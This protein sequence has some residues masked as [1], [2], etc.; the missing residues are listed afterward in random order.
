[1]KKLF[2]CLS[3]A[4]CCV[5]WGQRNLNYDESKVPQFA[6]P[7][8][9]TCYDGSKVTTIDDW[10]R[11]RRPELLETFATQE[12][13]RT[14]PDSIA[15]SYEVVSENSHALGDKAT[16]R[17][18]RF[19]FSGNGRRHEAIAMTLVPNH[20][21]GKVPVFVSYSFI[22]N[23]STTTDTTIVYSAGVRMVQ[24]PGD[25]NWQRGNQK[26]RWPFEQIIDRGYAVITMAYH[27]IY[28]D[29]D[30]PRWLDN[31]VLS[32]FPDYQQY[33]TRSDAWEAVGAWAWGSS[34]M[35]DYLYTQDWADMQRIALMGHSRQG[36]A[37][38]WA[39]AQDTRFRV[40][41]SNCSGASGAALAKRRYGETVGLLTSVRPWWFCAAYAFYT[42]REEAMPFDQHELIA[43]IAPRHVYVASAEDDAPA[44]PKGEFLATSYAEPVYRLYGLKGLDT[45]V[46]PAT[47]HPIMH[48]AG[49]HIRTGIHDVTDYD[50]Q[51]YMDFC[52]LHFK[53]ALK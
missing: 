3:L 31:S 22:G 34:R 19:L 44:D 42:D 50:W 17:Q 43:L 47:N 40:V 41:I 51:R 7:D 1:M 11:K 29:R 48:D 37:A 46:M 2:L 27:D 13:G 15:V 21:K 20:R 14:R 4:S 45:D 36:K 39:G 25:A 28:P 53:G 5:A 38:L 18:V 12:Y 32:L 23:H 24:K 52:D 33:A 8:V 35:V 9:L 49:Y 26:S 16:L 6:L 10:E 30:G